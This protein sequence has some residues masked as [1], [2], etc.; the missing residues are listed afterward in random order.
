VLRAPL[1]P[2][3]ASAVP[4]LLYCSTYVLQALE[5][6]PRVEQVRL[7]SCMSR[8]ASVPVLP[9]MRRRAKASPNVH[10][11]VDTCAARLPDAAADGFSSPPGQV[12]LSVGEGAPLCCP[13][14]SAVASTA[15]RADVL[16]DAL[17]AGAGGPVNVDAVRRDVV[18]ELALLER[19]NPFARSHHSDSISTSSPS[20]AK[21]FPASCQWAIDRLLF[22]KVVAAY[23]GLTVKGNTYMLRNMLGDVTP[24][25][26][27]TL[28]H[29]WPA[30]YTNWGEG[31]ENL[32]MPP[33][34]YKNPRN[35]L[36]LTRSLH[37]AFDNGHVV[38]MPSRRHITIRFINREA[39]DG[40]LDKALDGRKLFIP[41]RG[42]APYKRQLAYFA[43]LAQGNIRDGA[44]VESDVRGS[45]SASGSKTGNAVVQEL[46]GK[47]QRNLQLEWHHD[48]HTG[49]HGAGSGRG[50]RGGRGAARSG[51]GVG[52]G[53]RG[54]GRGRGRGF[55]W[56][57]QGKGAASESAA[58]AKADM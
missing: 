1:L 41:R 21:S 51:H 26:K 4:P 34:F 18:A 48:D 7:P 3:V 15:P 29:I 20:A 30:S 56:G 52:G 39:L 27:V 50:A 22:K 16:L 10:S 14:L 23:Y 11:R 19:L 38:L 28:A 6:L 53:G 44:V 49:G 57:G 9:R 8:C 13:L 55:G 37:K 45:L 40:K 5:V 35:F 54:G 46:T 24:F 2:D 31:C 33:E 42:A 47:L 17:V 25:S 43:M 32:A 36:L 12:V 58:A